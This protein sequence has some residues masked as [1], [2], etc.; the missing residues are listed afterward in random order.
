MNEPQTSLHHLRVD[1]VGSL[2]R[3]ESLKEAFFQY[4]QGVISVE[5]LRQAQDEA[6]RAVVR[7][8]EALNLP[9]VT[10]G[11]FRRWQFQD[12]FGVAVTGFRDRFAAANP[13]TATPAGVPT[14]QLPVPGART[15]D[16]MRS[17]LPV[18]ERLRLVRHL[19]L[20]EYRFTQSLTRTPVKVTVLGA[21]RI[22]H[23][24]D[25]EASRP[26]YHDVDAFMS[27]VVSILRQ[28]V[29]E[30]VAAG[31]WYVQIDA[32]AYTAYVDPTWLETMR[33]WGDD[34]DESLERAIRADNAIIAGFPGVTFGIHICR[35]NNR[36]MWHREGPYDAIAERLFQGLDHH[37][38][39]LEYDTERAGSFA[40]LRF[41][42]KGKMVVLGLIST[43]FPTLERVDDLV[44]RID[45][46]SHYVPLDQIAISPQ[47]G[48]AS[49]IMGNL[50]SEDDQWRKL[51]V[52][53]ETAAKVWG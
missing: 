17:R 9:I 50:L 16:P 41:I 34:P 11:E 49:G 5:E 24:F 39:L 6:I 18:L 48:F 45:E 42:P 22:M 19:P 7:K 44:R 12:S 31:C 25:P 35:G 46:A 23:R 28:M 43:K 52:M 53:L 38:L 20:D 15:E 2:L 36:S 4:D 21:A 27:D 1:Q 13:L 30:L 26:V 47:C 37:R 10:D 29:Q 51:E 8:Q 40:P 33:R 14:R 3:P 32:P